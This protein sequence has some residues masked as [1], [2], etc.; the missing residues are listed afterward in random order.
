MQLELD[1]MTLLR[2]FVRFIIGAVFGVLAAM[3]FTPAIAAFV[4]MPG[5]NAWMLLVVILIS[6]LLGVFAPTIR[7]AFGRGFLLVGVACLALPISTMLLSG[8]VMNDMLAE[9]TN[10]G[11]T[12][13]GAGIAGTLMTGAAGFIGFFLGSILIIIGL[14]LA[15]GGRREV[16]LVK[17]SASAF[18]ER[19]EPRL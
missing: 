2:G 10:Q 17:Q 19:R 13:V 16:I 8:R 4:D 18:T 5:G 7:R 9:S 3:A 14:V 11:A 12:M 6:A 1:A 15:L